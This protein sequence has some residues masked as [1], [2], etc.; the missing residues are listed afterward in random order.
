MS[1]KEDNKCCGTCA[2]FRTADQYGNGWCDHYDEPEEACNKCVFY[3]V[4][5]SGFDNED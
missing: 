4:N 2:L 1:R 5:K 3:Q